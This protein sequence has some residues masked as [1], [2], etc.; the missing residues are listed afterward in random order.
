M[1]I[2]NN[3][4]EEISIKSVTNF[5]E[6]NLYVGDAIDV[7]QEKD[8]LQKEID[9]LEGQVKGIAKKLSNERFVDN[10]PEDVVNREKKKLSDMSNKIEQLRESLN[11]FK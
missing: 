9:R 10:A 8:R 3:P 2:I 4:L 5:A 1:I 7:D 11:S 6:I